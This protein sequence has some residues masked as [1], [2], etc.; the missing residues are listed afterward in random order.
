MGN[1]TSRPTHRPR[2]TVLGT[3]LIGTSWTALLLARG[4]RVTV[5]DPRPDTGRTL[6][7]D[8]ARLVP[9]LADLGLTLDPDT[10]DLTVA[11]DLTTAVR[12]ADAVQENGPERLDLKQQLWADV[13]AAAPADALLLTSTSALTATEVSTR[14]SDPGRLVVGHPFNP[15]HLV[16]LVEVVPG[17]DTSP[18]TVDRVV[19]FY[20]AL[21]KHPVVLRREVPGFVA[22]RLQSALFREA[23]HLVREGVVDVAGLDD[24][25]TSSIGPRWAAA[26]PFRSFHLG[27]GPGGMAHFLTHL[28]PGMADGWEHLGRPVLD[29]ATTSDLVAQSEQATD[30]RDVADLA[31]ERD[32]R[33]AAVLAALAE[34]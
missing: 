8:L 28:G 2:T 22:N 19:E 23:V 21:G 26:G 16:P 6:R 11:D 31:R 25:V 7:A 32:T 5:H 4:H 9:G 13:E 24:V 3:G 29:E 12:G 33:Q 14:M 18:A 27:G 10:D 20:T 1:P 34:Q 15:P 17:R 30:G